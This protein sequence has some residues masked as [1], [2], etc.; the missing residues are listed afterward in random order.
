MAT[1]L[2]GTGNKR[3]GK[4]TPNMENF[5]VSL[6]YEGLKLKKSNKDKTIEDLKRKYS[7]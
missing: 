2:T 4:F 6:S 1:E 5:R 7:R 3:A